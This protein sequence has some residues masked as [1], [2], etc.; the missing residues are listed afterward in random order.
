M[1]LA[2]QAP[3]KTFP[4]LR[5]WCLRFVKVKAVRH[6]MQTSESVHSGGYYSQHTAYGRIKAALTALLSNM[7]LAICS[8][9]GKW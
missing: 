8:F 3:Q 2:E 7:L 9:G 6:R 5:Q 1:L 4:Q